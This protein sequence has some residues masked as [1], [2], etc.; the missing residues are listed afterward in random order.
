MSSVPMVSNTRAL[1]NA[2]GCFSTGVTVLT[3]ITSDGPMGMTVNSFASVSLDPPLIL[4]SVSKHSGR[5]DPF[6]RTDYF[7]V[8]VLCD[9]HVDTANRFATGAT[10]FSADVWTHGTFNTLNLKDALASF[11]CSIEALHDGGDH[12]IVVGRVEHAIIGNGEPLLFYK[13]QFG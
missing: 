9:Q 10:D 5:Y 2:L 7:S 12:T 8:N 13:G 11:E 6:T 3:V 1:R 4:W